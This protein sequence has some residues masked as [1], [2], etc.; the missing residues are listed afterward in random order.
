[1]KKTTNY[2]FVISLL[3]LLIII[4][5]MFKPIYKTLQILFV[6]IFIN[7]AL[8][9]QTYKGVVIRV[10]DG[11]TFVFQTTEGSFKV[12]MLAIDAPEHDQ[13]YGEESK[14]FLMQFLNKAARLESTGLDK[15][16]RHLAFLFVD[17]ENVNLLS[18]KTGNAW[19]YQHYNNDEKFIQAELYARKL[20]LGLWKDPNP[21][22]PWDWRHNK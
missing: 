13:P 3:F 19:H 15:Y 12:R 16:G 10:V 1:M 9:G 4:N 7:I 21:V 18:V 17:Q 2:L 22:A 11:D 6:S 8:Y 14:V 20:K 5:N